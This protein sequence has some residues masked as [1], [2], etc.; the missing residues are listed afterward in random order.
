M[1]SF[2]L[3]TLHQLRYS[4]TQLTPETVDKVLYQLIRLTSN[5]EKK[6]RPILVRGT[7]YEMVY[8]R[9]SG[10]EAGKLREQICDR[11]DHIYEQPCLCFCLLLA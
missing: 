3:I 10:Q 1:N 11:F 5:I 9:Y 7:A 6:L 8:R 2:E 4:D